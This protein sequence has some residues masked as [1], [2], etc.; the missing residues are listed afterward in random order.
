MEEYFDF[1]LTS[2]TF[3]Y[4]RFYV[5]FK[6]EVERKKIIGYIFVI[7]KIRKYEIYDAAQKK[8]KRI[9]TRSREREKEEEERGSRSPNLW[10]RY[11]LLLLLLLMWS[12]VQSWKFCI[13]N[14]TW[15]FSP[16][17]NIVFTFFIIVSQFPV[18]T[19]LSLQIWRLFR[20]VSSFF[21]PLFTANIS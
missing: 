14:V 12:Y 17:S 7:Q 15:V 5:K 6:E 1:F 10:D 4:K 16:I 8:K 13:S 2:K 11:C 9:L 18:K 20:F 3:N 19:V 21:S